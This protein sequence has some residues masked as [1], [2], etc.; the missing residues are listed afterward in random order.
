M[1]LEQKVQY[2]KGVGPKKSQALARLGIVLVYDLLTYYPRRY[3]DQS[4]L[5]TIAESVP[6]EEGTV[7]GVIISVTESCP[8][9]GLKILKALVSDGSAYIQLSWFNQPYLKAKIKTGKKIFAKN[10]VNSGYKLKHDSCLLDYRKL[11]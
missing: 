10:M 11:L 2:I 7:S 6:G 9:R 4:N 1:K 3:E 8:R 5:R